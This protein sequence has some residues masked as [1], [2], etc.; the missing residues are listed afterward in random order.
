[1]VK[2]LFPIA[3]A[4]V[5]VPVLQT[6]SDS[7]I[8]N[9][10]TQIPFVVAIVWLILKLVDKQSQMMD[11]ITERHERSLKYIVE[12]F[13][14]MDNRRDNHNQVT[15]SALLAVLG[16]A[17]FVE[18]GDN[19]RSPIEANDIPTTTRGRRPKS[20]ASTIRALK[21]RQTTQ[22]VLLDHILD[23]E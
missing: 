22:D 20:H 11:N 1:M 19:S 23:D 15:V 2:L 13:E 18:A 14:I 3:L 9:M 16:E 6:P 12:Q 21:R 7:T 5:I 10:L 4:S 17:G 8:F